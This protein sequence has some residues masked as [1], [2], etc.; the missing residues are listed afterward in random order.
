MV[1][2]Y[3]SNIPAYQPVSHVQGHEYNEFGGS[4][5]E[6]DSSMGDDSLVEKSSTAKVPILARKAPKAMLAKAWSKTTSNKSSSNSSEATVQ[7]S[8]MATELV[9][10]SKKVLSEGKG[11]SLPGPERDGIKEPPKSS[12]MAPATSAN[13]VSSESQNAMMPISQVQPIPCYNCGGAGHQFMK[14]K[15]SCGGCGKAGHAIWAC[16]KQAPEQKKRQ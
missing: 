11:R 2:M 5:E 8:A 6:V 15:V 13:G 3:Q 10:R 16:F 4:F 9:I 12:N 1:P 7:G 14:C